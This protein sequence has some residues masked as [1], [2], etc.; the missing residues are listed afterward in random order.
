MANEKIVDA[1]LG[2]M[3]RYTKNLEIQEH[4]LFGL[5]KVILDSGESWG[6]SG[7]ESAPTLILPDANRT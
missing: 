1:I 2:A 4:A 7:V 3:E 5:G 6:R